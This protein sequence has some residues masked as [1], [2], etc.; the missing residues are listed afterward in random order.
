MT[1]ALQPRGVTAEI[2]VSE[3][4]FV[5]EDMCHKMSLVSRIDRRYQL[6]C[7]GETDVL[8]PC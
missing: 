1:V 7:K 8:G 3:E 4:M 2:L 6:V 5:N